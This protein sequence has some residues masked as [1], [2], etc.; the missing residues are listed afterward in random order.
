MFVIIYNFIGLMLAVIRCRE[1]YG[2]IRYY[3]YD[4]IIYNI[5]T[6]Y[7]VMIYNF[8]ISYCIIIYICILYNMITLLGYF[9]T[10]LIKSSTQR[11]WV[12]YIP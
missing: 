1:H 2:L 6:L 11:T 8:I 9:L 5:V 4:I 10:I 7:Q 12:Y 3:C